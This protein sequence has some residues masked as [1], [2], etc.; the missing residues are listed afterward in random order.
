[1]KYTTI[2]I[3]IILL[4]AGLIAGVLYAFSTTPAAQSLVVEGDHHGPPASVSSAG[5]DEQDWHPEHTRPRTHTDI[6][7]HTEQGEHAAHEQSGSLLNALP[8]I[9]LHMALI[10]LLTA[11]IILLDKG[12]NVW[13]TRQQR[14]ASSAES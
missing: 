2:R 12:I 11:F 10:G 6:Q 8:G 4:C 13:R 5:Q 3:M 14:L 1:M 9:G 7:Q